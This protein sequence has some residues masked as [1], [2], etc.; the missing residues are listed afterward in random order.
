MFLNSNSSDST[1]EI[2]NILNFYHILLTNVFYGTACPGP[3]EAPT[4]I[5][6]IP[7]HVDLSW[8]RPSANGAWMY[9]YELSY[10]NGSNIVPRQS[11]TAAQIPGPQAETL[12]I[13][14]ITAFP[15]SNLCP[16]QF[17]TFSFMTSQS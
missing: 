8:S 13:V 12:Y 1:T 9:M 16:D 11:A 10:T 2:S 4:V 7:P 5:S 6:D 3:P 17:T 14:V 15:V